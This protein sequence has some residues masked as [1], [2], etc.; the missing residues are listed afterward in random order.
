MV[1]IFWYCKF[2]NNFSVFILTLFSSFFTFDARD[3]ISNLFENK[4]GDFNEKS[5]ESWIIIWFMKSW[6]WKSGWNG[7]KKRKGNRI[8]ICSDLC[9]QLDCEHTTELERA[10]DALDVIKSWACVTS[11]VLRM[12]RHSF[13]SRRFTAS[14][15][16]QKLLIS[17]WNP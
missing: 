3:F 15:A 11:H 12:W 4:F 6:N 8:L 7:W 17:L 1:H 2:F 10:M 9:N 5:S 14:N 13:N 16:V